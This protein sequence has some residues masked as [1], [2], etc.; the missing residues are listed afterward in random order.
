MS[1]TADTLICETKMFNLSTRST[2]CVNLNGDY[3]SR[4]MYSINNMIDR[5]EL[6]E[7]VMFSIPNAVIPV[8]FYTVN[9]NNNILV[10]YDAIT[11]T[12]STVTFPYGNY[13]ANSFISEFNNN[14]GVLGSYRISLDPL[15]SKF[16]LYSSDTY[17]T[18]KASSTISSVMGFSSDLVS[19]INYSP[20][21]IGPTN[22]KI[23]VTIN[24]TP[25]PLVVI[26]TIPSNTYDITTGY[27][28]NVVNSLFAIQLISTTYNMYA[29]FK[30]DANG[31]NPRL[32]L[33]SSYSF[34]QTPITNNLFADPIFQHA[35]LYQSI[36]DAA[37]C[38]AQG[39]TGTNYSLNIWYGITFS[40][41]AF[42][43]TCNFLPLPRILLRCSDLANTTVIGQKSASDIIV[44]IPNEAKPNGQIYYQN[45]TQAQ[46]L[47]RR[48]DLQNFIISFS[49]DDG[50]PINFNG[51]SSFFTLQFDIYRK[52]VPRPPRFADIVGYVT[53]AINEKDNP[54]VPNDIQLTTID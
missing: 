38:T 51:V 54:E 22:N 43:R 44:T 7:Y 11:N 17:F 36:Q 52:A 18:F 32:V 12:T 46:L 14:S 26:I 2:G 49:D 28:I 45:Q 15:T 35:G 47:F 34:Q 10:I 40:V 37:Y 8:S 1:A 24:R 31:L 13:T 21:V 30:K 42:P 53:S 6:I 20:L 25:N 41:P 9:E 39:L 48:Y 16:S 33:S 23:C 29:A 4:C 19:T 50:N 27:F 5:D 3:K